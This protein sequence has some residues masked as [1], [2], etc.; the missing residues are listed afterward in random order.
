M[1]HKIFPRTASGDQISVTFDYVE[2]KDAF[3][4]AIRDLKD[5]IENTPTKKFAFSTTLKFEVARDH[6]HEI[7]QIL[8]LRNLNCWTKCSVNIALPKETP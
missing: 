1:K 6:S 8:G 3:E 2:E 4:A 5:H 7:T